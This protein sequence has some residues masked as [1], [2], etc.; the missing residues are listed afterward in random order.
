VKS[1]IPFEVDDI[2]DRSGRQIVEDEDFVAALE[3]R[4]GQVAANESCATR[5]QHPHQ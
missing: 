4:F 1:R 3:Q 2:L 5:N